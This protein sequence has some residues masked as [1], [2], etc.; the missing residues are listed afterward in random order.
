M[1]AQA[2]WK[3]MRV[4]T[5]VKIKVNSTRMRETYHAS[6]THADQKLRARTR[7][8]SSRILARANS[9][10]RRVQILTEVVGPEHFSLDLDEALAE[11][12]IERLKRK[13]LG[14]R[15]GLAILMDYKH[16]SAADEHGGEVGHT[17]RRIWGW[18]ITRPMSKSIVPRSAQRREAR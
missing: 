8:N 1:C 9:S 4:W 10:R 16:Q 14:N 7:A 2:D 11:F 13:K 15:R 3:K 6:P 17:T 12:G 18:H 5:R